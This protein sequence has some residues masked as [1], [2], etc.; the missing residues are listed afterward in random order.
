MKC[1]TLPA[2]DVLFEAGEFLYHLVG[3]IHVSNEGLRVLCLS[4]LPSL[5][6]LA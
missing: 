4:L 6:V 5:R 2:E 3:S 1:L